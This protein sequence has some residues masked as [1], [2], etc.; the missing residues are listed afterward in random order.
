MSTHIGAEPGQIAEHILLPGDPLRA[1][2][3]A[4]TYLDDAQCYTRVRGMLGF[5]GTYRGERISVQGTGMGMPSS[6]IYVTELLEEYGVRTLIRVGSCGSMQSDLG[7]LDVV[8]A[9]SACTDSAMNRVR[10]RGID[11]AS[12][13]DFGLLRTAYD[14]AQQRGVDVR[15]GPIASWDAFYPADPTLLM[16]LADYGVLAVEMESAALYTLAAGAGARALTICQVSDS[17]ITNEHTPAEQ[18]ERG[19]ATAAELALETVHALATTSSPA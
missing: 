10:F 5:T 9:T 18:R 8:L 16:Q 19:L 1:E 17:L 12:T 3:I 7:L 2:W 14:V 6:S 11:F 15:V 13:A 4:Q